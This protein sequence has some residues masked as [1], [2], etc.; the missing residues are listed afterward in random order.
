MKSKP[1]RTRQN[2]RN[3]HGQ[4]PAQK[5][6]KNPAMRI[7]DAG[8]F[9]MAADEMAADAVVAQGLLHMAKGLGLR[10]LLLKA[11]T[12]MPDKDFKFELPEGVQVQ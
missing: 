4:R 2:R 9:E 8:L 12:S 5:G 7:N 3:A 11:F 10:D 1:K 6:R